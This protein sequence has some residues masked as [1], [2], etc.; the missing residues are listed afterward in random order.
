MHKNLQI[1]IFFFFS[2]VKYLWRNVVNYRPKKNN[3]LQNA[4]DRNANSSVSLISRV[5]DGETNF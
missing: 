2:F 1:P 4:S 5:Q 3:Y